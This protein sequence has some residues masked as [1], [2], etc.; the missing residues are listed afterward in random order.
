M[1]EVDARLSKARAAYAGLKHL[2]HGR[3]TPL[4]LKGRVYRA[5]V[6]SVLFCGCETRNSRAEDVGLLNIFNHRCSHSIARIGWGDRVS[7]VQVMNLVLSFGL[8]N[9][10]SQ[11]QELNAIR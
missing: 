3:D 6:P 4:K 10:L 8:G 1:T 7:S 11:L 9:S 5:P 2:W